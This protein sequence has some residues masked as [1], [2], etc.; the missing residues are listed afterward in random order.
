MRIGILKETKTPPD[1]RVPLTPQQ[2]RSVLDKYSSVEIYV[3]PDGYRSFTNE[4]YRAAGV[5]LKEDISFCDVLMGVKEVTISELISGKSYFFFSHTAKKQ[6]YNRDLLQALVKNKIRMIDYEYLTN[7]N[8]ER[9]V[10]FGRWA[11]IVG[12][13]NALITYG[14]R[15]QKFK[16]KPAW[17]CRDK[18]ELFDQL[19]GINPGSIKI[20]ITGGGRVAQGAMETLSII[21]LKKVSP[22]DFLNSEFS[23][24]VYTQ[25]DPWDYVK[26]LDNQKFELL[27]FFNF[28]AEYQTTFLPYTK[29]TDI[30]IACHFWDPRSP[31]F[32]TRKDM[33]AKDFKIKVIAD[34]SCDIKGPIPST[35]RAST[36]ADPIYGYSPETGLEADPFSPANISVM[37][38][39]NLPGELPRDASEDFGAKLIDEVIPYLI[40]EK[41]GQIIK[42][43]TITENG[44]LT[45]HFTYLEDYLNGVE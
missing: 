40:G 11:G 31:V 7:D 19:K 45:E 17:Q 30:F 21:G 37:A 3:Q 5:T 43:A 20:V 6:P 2:C 42:K 18:K 12:A 35:I 22:K 32:I 38:V 27:H 15:F 44:K 24:A 13:Y 4:E 28:P 10:A 36:I 23:E 8:N 34:V 25:L 9:V 14:K 39:D 41:Q 26:R 1:R 16:L 33:Q 29:L